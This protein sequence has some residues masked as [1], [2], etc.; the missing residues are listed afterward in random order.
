MKRQTAVNVTLV[1]VLFI[2]GGLCGLGART[3]V[4]GLGK[5]SAQLEQCALASRQSHANEEARSKLAHLVSDV[6]VCMN[7]AGY[8]KAPDNKNCSPTIWQGDVF[9]Y[10][11]KSYL[12][13]LVYR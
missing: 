2:A 3:L 9:C 1:A 4:G 7:H 13:K 8:E 6:P 5:Q 12:G 11:P 10:V